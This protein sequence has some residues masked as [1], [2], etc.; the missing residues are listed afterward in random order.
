MES[1]LVMALTAM[2]SPSLVVLPGLRHADIGRV[3]RENLASFLGG[4]AGPDEGHP[5]PLTVVAAARGRAVT[6]MV[7]QGRWDAYA[8][9]LFRDNELVAALPYSTTA[10]LTWTSLPPGRYRVRIFARNA[11]DA[12]PTARTTDWVVVS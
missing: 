2:A 10:S 6:G 11:G 4:L 1:G 9:R 7:L 3:Y 8:G 12:D 5:V